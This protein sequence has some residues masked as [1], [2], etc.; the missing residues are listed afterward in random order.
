M[1]Q[2]LIPYVQDA[3]MGTPRPHYL[4]GKAIV[5]LLEENKIKFAGKALFPL[6]DVS[7]ADRK[8]HVNVTAVLFALWNSA[9]LMARYIEKKNFRITRLSSNYLKTFLPED[10]VDFYV[11]ASF[12]ETPEARSKDFI[13]K[14]VPKKQQGKINSLAHGKLQAIFKLDNEKV[15]EIECKFVGWD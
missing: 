9:H 8:D 13:A 2:I 7:I 11:S 5:H 3:L 6:S 1:K 14:L 10:I 15:A 12:N 4:V